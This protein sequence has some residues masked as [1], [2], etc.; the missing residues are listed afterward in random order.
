MHTEP[1]CSPNFM[2]PIFLAELTLTKPWIAGIGVAALVL[3]YLAFKTAKFVMK[4]VLWIVVIAA[5]AFAAWW[6]YTG[7]RSPL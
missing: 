5:I 4:L 3:L 1:E 2:N 7:H 6:F